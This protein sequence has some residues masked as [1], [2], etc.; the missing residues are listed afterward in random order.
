MQNMFVP[1][2]M[3]HRYISF[4]LINKNVKNKKKLCSFYLP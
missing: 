2:F 4:S 3:C 1:L